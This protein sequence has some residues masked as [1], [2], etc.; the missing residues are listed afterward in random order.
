MADME[1]K[2]GIICDVCCGS[3]AVGLSLMGWGRFSC[4]FRYPKRS[5]RTCPIVHPTDI[6][7]RGFGGRSRK[8][9]GNLGLDCQDGLRFLHGDCL[10]PLRGAGLFNQ[11]DLIVSN[12]PYSKRR[13]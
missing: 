4:F 7:H 9:A 5:K 2:D 3:G 10:E 12:P 11:V 8:P 13:D 6:S 1:I